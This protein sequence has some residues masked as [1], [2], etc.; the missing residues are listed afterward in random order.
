VREDQWL[1]ERLAALFRQR[2][3]AAPLAVALLRQKGPQARITNALAVAGSPAAM[4]ALGNLARDSSVPVAIRV[5]ALTAFVRLHS[6]SPEMMRIGGDLLS[7]SNSQVRAAACLA[8]GALARAGRSEHRA[9]ADAIDAALIAR[10]RKAQSIGELSDLLAGFGNS[11]GP[12]VLPAIEESLRDPRPTV[13]A[14]AVKGLRLAE[15]PEVDG[16]LSATITADA[17]PEV[18]GTAIFA[19]SFRTPTVSLGEALQQAAR[20]DSAEY[21]RAKAVGLLRQN[22]LAFPGVS[23]TLAWVAEHDDKPGVRRLALE[24][25]GSVSSQH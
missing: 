14:A 11:V 15:A 3:E 12:A 10:Y 20:G 22:S 6:P 19:A 7:D 1:P 8:S 21:V 18:R 13:R 23:A 5:D 9:Q 24:G 17:D 2:P 25:L 16:L 4:D